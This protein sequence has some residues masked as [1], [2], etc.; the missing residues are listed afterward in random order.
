M[1]L[2]RRTTFKS[3]TK[4]EMGTRPTTAIVS[5]TPPP[6]KRIVGAHYAHTRSNMNAQTTWLHHGAVKAMELCA[7]NARGFVRQA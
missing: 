2:G 7:T 5:A 4:P 6:R 3:E 1:I